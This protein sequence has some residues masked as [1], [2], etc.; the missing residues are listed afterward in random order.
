MNYQ[1][2]KNVRNASW[3]CLIDCNITELPISLS[4]IC[5]HYNVHIIK[6]SS[7]SDNKLNSNQRGKV[8]YIDDNC[9]IVVDDHEPMPAQRYTISHE[10][11]HILCGQDEYQAERFAIG[12]LAPAI[13]LHKLN[14]SAAKDIAVLCNISIT[15]AQRRAERIKILNQRK[16]FLIHPL[17]RQVY[18][19]FKPF[20]NL[21][22]SA[23]H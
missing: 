20:I 16:K 3:Q 10:L 1:I 13:V 5:S 6:N 11:G 21:K 7:L 22:G 18:D 17:E 4:K 15:A 19:Q 2:Y 12:I 8:M 9:Y 14:V 23:S